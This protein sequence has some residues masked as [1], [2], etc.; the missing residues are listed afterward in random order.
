MFDKD[1]HTAMSITLKKNSLAVS[2]QADIK[3]KGQ[4]K[5]MCNNFR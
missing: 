5:I 3:I 2:T 1:R 4:P